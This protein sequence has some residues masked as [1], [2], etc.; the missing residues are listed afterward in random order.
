LCACSS[1]GQM[2]KINLEVPK[3]IDLTDIIS[4]RSNV[5]STKDTIGGELYLPPSVIDKVPA[6]VIMHSS[7]GVMGYRE[8]RLASDLNS[9]GIAAYIPYSFA[10]RGIYQP[11]QTSGTGISFGMRM[12]EAYAALN[13]LSSHP[14]INPDKIG[15]V[16]YSSGGVVSLLSTD[17]KIRKILARSNNKFAASVN[18]YPGVIFVFANPTPTKAPVLFL[19]G[20]IDDI[21]PMGKVLEY[22]ERLK[23]AGGDVQTKVYPGAYHGFDIPPTRGRRVTSVDNDSNCQF[24]I[25]DNGNFIDP[26]NGEIFSERDWVSHEKSCITNNGMMSAR[27][28][29]AANEYLKDTIDFFVKYLT[30]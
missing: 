18:I 10:S 15:I 14:K 9:K 1:L 5:N 26:K 28:S 24:E 21:V 2:E 17:E 6:V 19:L 4:G 11:R 27:D 20:E 23:K 29:A 22:A 30:P 7:S 13:M 16:G 12:E 8:I 3:D 25:Q